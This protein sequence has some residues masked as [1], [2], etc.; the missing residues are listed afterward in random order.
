MG[1]TMRIYMFVEIFSRIRIVSSAWAWRG[2]GGW[3]ICWIDRWLR[4]SGTARERFTGTGT[5]HDKR[6]FLVGACL[7]GI[8]YWSITVSCAAVIHDHI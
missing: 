3:H 6:L 7:C 5:R 8:N 2:R 4:D 1:S